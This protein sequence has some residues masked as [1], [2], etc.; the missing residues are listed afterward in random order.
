MYRALT[1][2]GV[3]AL[4]STLTL[5]GLLFTKIG[6]TILLPFAQSTLNHFLPFQVQLQNL[7]IALGSVRTDFTINKTIA[8]ALEGEYSISGSINMTARVHTLDS[9]GNFDSSPSLGYLSL[10]GSAI[11]YTIQSLPIP[12]DLKAQSNTFKLFARMKLLCIQDYAIE[13]RAVPVKQLEQFFGI[14]IGTQGAISIFAQAESSTLQLRAQ[15]DEFYFGGFAMRINNLYY[16][17]DKSRQEL[18]GTL[19]LSQ[20]TFSLL[21]ASD[22]ETLQTAIYSSLQTPIAS[23]QTRIIDKT[24]AY[25]LHITNLTALGS[26]FGIDINGK[27]ELQGKIS[28]DNEIAFSATSSSFGGV[29][30]L[31]LKK[32]TLT[33]NG[34]NLSL[35]RILQL[36]KAPAILDST[37]MV[38]SVYNL[39]FHKGTITIKGQNFV[40]LLDDLET[41][42]LEA[43]DTRNNAQDAWGVGFE[44]ARADS[45]ISL[46]GQLEH[47]QINA[48]VTIKTPNQSLHTSKCMIN[49]ATQSL[50]IEL[51]ES[52]IKLQGKL[53]QIQVP[54][55][56]T[57]QTTQGDLQAIYENQETMQEE[58]EQK[59]ENLGI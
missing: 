38:T 51:L 19:T 49:L 58:V 1:W 13:L 31:T 10:Q 29:S 2:V 16:K 12:K 50:D 20:E 35:M 33:F 43:F 36:A 34:E 40:I 4:C 53:S 23:V 48:Q 57:G 54:L 55:I 3:F 17:R 26:A 45:T 32:N 44:N 28:V 22:N 39:A 41:Y 11:N 5:G 21:G 27:L 30:A 37:L 9:N 14:D 52:S 24:L 47:A 6:N 56:N 7:T 18:A 42:G 59:Q 15:S 8:I 46:D 25:N